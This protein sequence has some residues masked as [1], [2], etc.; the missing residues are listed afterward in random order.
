MGR[1][2]LGVGG[3]AF[4]G[5]VVLAAATAS[6][7]KK[8]P[9]LLPYVRVPVAAEIASARRIGNDVYVTVTIP[10]VDIDELTPAS[11]C[12]VEVYAATAAAPPPIAQFLAVGARV[13]TIPV[14]RYP[15]PSD[16]NGTVTPDP[17][18]GALQGAS[19]TIKDTLTTDEMSA[20]ELPPPKTGRSPSAAAPEARP[21][22]TGPD[23][24][25]RFYMT[26]P[27]NCN[28]RDRRGGPPSKLVEVPMA[29]VPD[30]VAGLRVSQKGRNIEVE[31]EPSGGVLGF[32]IDR[33]LPLEAAPVDRP[34][35][36]SAP[37]A[38]AGPTRY[39]VYR[40]TAPDP[41]ALPPPAAVE[42]RWAAAPATP[43]NAQPVTTLSFTDVDVPFDERTRCY[44]V[45]AVRGTDAQRVESE[46]SES[47]CVVPI[48]TE[49]PT[50]VTGLTATAA[51]GAITVRWEPNGE[52]DL[53]GYLV[54]RR[55]AGDDTLRLLTTEGPKADTRHIDATVM[56]GR[57]Y[58]YV[59]Q[60]VDNRLPAPN[61]SEP[62]EVN[63]TAP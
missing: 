49:A 3:W 42:S 35:A 5:A 43:A 54:L 37:A 19:V 8:G 25:R 21:G 46:S 28:R 57:M 56:S 4:A 41:L 20:R 50:Q 38:A 11:V 53:R 55:E 16:G 7:G 26:V 24:L 47:V 22:Q 15:D 58:T 62:A 33:A 31:W 52:E 30:K 23:A 12:E 10:T 61:V 2:E 1:W 63:A 59:V 34:A 60:A 48:D 13:E 27:F 51:E 39:N 45:R 32:L 9:P 40:E 14:A 6:C 29:N 44:Q 18:S 36:S 17:K